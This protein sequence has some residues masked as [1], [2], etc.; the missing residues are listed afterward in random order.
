MIRGQGLAEIGTEVAALAGFTIV[1][2]AIGLWRF[3]FE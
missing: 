3:S 1:F 2:T